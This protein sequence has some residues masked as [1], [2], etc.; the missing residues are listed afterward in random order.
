MAAAL[1]S[2]LLAA[3]HNL[4]KG[5]A[6]EH[7]PDFV[8]TAGAVV[9]HEHVVD[10][11]DEVRVVVVLVAPALRTGWSAAAGG[12]RLLEYPKLG[13]HFLYESLRYTEA[14]AVTCDGINVDKGD[15]NSRGRRGRI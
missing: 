15:R 14:R 8:L 11:D 1:A 12:L 7:I 4:A 6:A 13:L 9:R 3:P 5:A 10:A 2:A